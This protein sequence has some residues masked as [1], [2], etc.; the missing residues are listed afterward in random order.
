MKD[1]TEKAKRLFITGRIH[2][3][4]KLSHDWHARFAQG[5]MCGRKIRRHN[6]IEKGVY[7][8]IRVRYT[9]PEDIERSYFE[10][11]G[12]IHDIKPKLGRLYGDNREFYLYHGE[13]YIKLVH[14]MGLQGGPT[15]ELY[16]IRDDTKPRIIHDVERLEVY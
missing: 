11:H 16:A 5:G 2:E 10:D 12:P 15:I 4:E 14:G 3:V 1:K 8:N 9:N 7:Y 6:P 13:L